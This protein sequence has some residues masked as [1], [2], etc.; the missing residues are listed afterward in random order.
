MDGGYS[1]GR[2][3]P[4]VTNL[5]WQQLLSKALTLAV[6][7]VWNK[8]ILVITQYCVPIYNQR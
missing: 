8:Q 2:Q 5:A 6:K 1:S 3:W 7:R 4:L